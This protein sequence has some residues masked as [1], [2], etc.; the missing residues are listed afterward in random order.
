MSISG[1]TNFVDIL[2]RTQAFDESS[3]THASQAA[4]IGDRYVEGSD[5]AVQAQEFYEHR[6][7]DCLGVYMPMKKAKTE[8]QR[9]GLNDVNRTRFAYGLSKNSRGKEREG[10]GRRR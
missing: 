5:T 2:A 1:C 6:R 8:R 9:G 7:R 10:R 4:T 3:S